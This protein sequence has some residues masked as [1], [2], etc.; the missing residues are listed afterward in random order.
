MRLLS[1]LIL[2]LCLLQ[3]CSDSNPK[4][5]SSEADKK[6]FS[7]FL[8]QYF[9][10]LLRFTPLLATEIND[11][12]YNHLLP[13]DI[14]RPYQDS[15]KT[16]YSDY[17][18][19]L[20][21]FDRSK[22]S[23]QEQLSFDILERELEMK[24]RELD[25]NLQYLP[26]NQF[27]G[28]TLFLPQIGSGQSIQPF[29][30]VKD[31]ENFIGR[32]QQFVPWAD[33][34]IVN[35]R[36]GLASGVTHP[37]VLM[38]KVVP[39][40]KAIITDDI[41]QN[42]FYQPIL[43][44]PDTFKAE[45]KERLKQLYTRSISE[46]IIPSYTRLHDF[47]R[48]E[49]ISKT[50][51]SSGISEIPE[52]RELYQYLINYWTTTNLSPEEIFSTGEKEVARILG[53]MEKVRTQVG[54][55]GDLKTFFEYVNKDKKFKPFN[56]EEEV[57]EA[58]RSIEQKMQPHV[59]KLFNKT[60]SIPFEIRQ[61]EEFREASASAEYQSGAPDGSRP[62]IFYVP[63]INPKEFNYTGME[64]LFLHEAI[65]GHHFQIALQQ[66][67]EEIPRFRRHNWYSAYGEGWAL[68]TESLGKQLGLYTDP[69]QY[70]GNLSD[71]IHRAI[72]LVVDVGI[73]TKGWSREKAIEYMLDNEA[74]SERDAIAEIERYMAIPGQAL[75]YKI[76]QLKIIELRKEAEKKLGDAF[77]PGLFHD[78]ILK[79]G[80]VPL[81]ILEDQITEWID[82]QL[83]TN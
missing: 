53:E 2:V 28:L 82:G 43:N 55:S 30:T 18:T 41:T 17:L 35:M 64:T 48:D 4:E 6:D 21:E 3:A 44:L 78:E 23:D 62:G 39:Q 71:E 29:G 10:E 32:M 50:R 56:T 73:H 22:L 52:G 40:L 61:T 14:S 15:L 7:L 59:K 79:N 63:I 31:Y 46:N 58:F 1:A 27:W 81:N 42:I 33:T 25:F 12:R 76:G 80:P 34:A 72:R 77:Q 38:E 74:I 24:L 20:K 75:S 51:T 11:N 37:K 26:I 5:T 16:F 83:T 70:F 45:D 67:N 49:Y 9:E 60:P 68:Y 13:N 8:E 66:E 47:I 69:Y 57:L 65:P 54:F 19:Q 36:K